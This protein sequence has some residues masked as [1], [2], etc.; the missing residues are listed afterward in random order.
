MDSTTD[1]LVPNQTAPN[2]SLI[3]QQIYLCKTSKEA[4]K[5][6]FGWAIGWAVFS[7]MGWFVFISGF[8]IGI[9][10]LPWGTGAAGEVC[11]GL[12]AVAAPLVATREELNSSA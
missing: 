7:V 11:G 2:N 1:L 6:R 4:P 9:F 12:G 3:T 10:Y 8:S 5:L